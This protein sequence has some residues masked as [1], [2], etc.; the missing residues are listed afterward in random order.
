M[1][2]M[3]IRVVCLLLLVFPFMGKSYAVNS[4][5]DR[6]ILKNA[7]KTGLISRE[8]YVVS[9]IETFFTANGRKSPGP[10]GT[11]I[12]GENRE[13]TLILKE[14]VQNYMFYSDASRRVV[15]RFLFRPVSP[16]ETWPWE[17]STGF[18]LPIPVAIPFK[19]TVD[20]YPH[21]GGKYTFW[22]VTHT[23]PDSGGVSHETTLDFVKSVA[24]TFEHVYE[25][26]VTE[27]GFTAPL[28]DAILQDNGGDGT[29][30]VYIMNC[31]YYGIYGYT[32]PLTDDKACPSYM[33][34]DNDFSEFVSEGVSAEQ[35]MEV[36]IAHEF[37]HSVQFSINSYADAWIMEATSTWMESDV[38]P[39]ITDNLQYLNGS[40]GFF[41]I[42]FVPI[43]D[44]EQTYNS[45]IFLQYLSLK[46]GEEIIKTLWSFL[47]YR[48][49][50]TS[51]VSSLLKSKST[52]L[53]TEFA[54]FV[55]IN[56][57]Q[58]DY[59][60][61]AEMYDEVYISNGKG[62]TLDDGLD[63]S[64]FIENIDTHV[65]HM[66][67]KYYRFI[68][69]DHLSND[70]RLLIEVYGE[71][72]AVVKAGL[73]VK[74]ADGTFSHRTV[75]LDGN[76]DGYLYVEGF[77]RDFVD[78]A[79]LELVNCSTNTDGSTFS[80]KGGIGLSTE[81]TKNGGGGGGGCFIESVL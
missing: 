10:P 13:L 43:D 39:E 4:G 41:S 6:E 73:T 58:S 34:V 22:Y 42:P 15:E 56:Y 38:Y 62:Q 49:D 21:I 67:A 32:M 57:S 27:M 71:D 25:K 60:P 16:S 11:G 64:P 26:E 7:M 76:N 66:A 45:W 75:A 2:Q 40:G 44:D 53:D 8:D 28:S 79:V 5:T 68:P 14:A 78:E 70:D 33:V 74:R 37:H 59:Y 23:K 48:M 17:D 30:D 18:Y 80:V 12:K 24:D 35:A 72:G 20:E 51:A 36:T 46:W 29:R 31:G 63:Y 77:S 47:L 61:D 52:S 19:P 9:R 55:Q 50:G 3:T 69:G 81:M 54:D 65:D 1:K